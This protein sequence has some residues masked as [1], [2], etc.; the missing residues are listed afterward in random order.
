MG[1]WVP[2]A[3]CL[4]GVASAKPGL[5]VLDPCR[6]STGGQ[7]ASGTLQATR[8]ASGAF[9]FV[10]SHLEM[11]RLS[12]WAYRIPRMITTGASLNGLF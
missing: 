1:K 3:A 10:W 9:P 2:R 5:P 6:E 8:S 11:P 4:P 7:A 12:G